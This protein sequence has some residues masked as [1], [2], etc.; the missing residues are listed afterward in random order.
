MSFKKIVS[1]EL[2]AGIGVGI[3]VALAPVAAAD[4]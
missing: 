2:L 3:A 1:V 4:G